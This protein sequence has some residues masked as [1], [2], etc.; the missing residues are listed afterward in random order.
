VKVFDGAMNLLMMRPPLESGAG[1]ETADLGK[2][3]AVA[4]N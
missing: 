1:W 2:T 4:M 3:G